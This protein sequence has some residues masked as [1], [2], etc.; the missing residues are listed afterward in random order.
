[1]NHYS[2]IG[3][4]VKNFEDVDKIVDDFFDQKYA[5]MMDWDIKNSE[6]QQ[7]LLMQK[8]G[9]I[10]LFAKVD[11]NRK[12]ILAFSFSHDNE[13]ISDVKVVKLND[14]GKTNDFKTVCIEKDGIPFWFAT[15]NAEIFFLDDKSDKIKIS[16]FANYV[17]IK[18]IQEI[19][20]SSEPQFAPES[21]VSK[22]FENDY[23]TGFV[24]GIIK[25]WTREKNLIT[26]KKYYA[27]D[28]DCMGLYFKMLVDI[29]MVKKSQLRVGKI[30]CGEF[31]NTA[32]LVANNH[33]DY[34]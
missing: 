3:F 2:D 19:K 5:K 12:S 11:S 34:F 8:I 15:P 1:M 14:G 10:R 27:I 24:S 22:F 33:P 29:N 18:D 32:I 23:T 28:A 16:S 30:I 20:N 21:Y 25:G 31:W 9:K 6:P 4:E 13:R 7:N 17:E 26:G